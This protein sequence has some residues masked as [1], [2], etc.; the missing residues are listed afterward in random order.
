M[1]NRGVPILK[2]ISGNRDQ[3]LSGSSENVTNVIL[4]DVILVD[5][6]QDTI[7]N[8]MQSGKSKD[9]VK[10]SSLSV[11]KESFP[12]VELCLLRQEAD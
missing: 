6:I 10:C 9:D 12:I 8:Q 1:D 7:P 2:V 4:K 3:N 5:A 11:Q